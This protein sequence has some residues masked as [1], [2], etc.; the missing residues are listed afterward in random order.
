[1]EVYKGVGISVLGQHLSHSRHTLGAA[2]Y[3]AMNGLY[4][5]VLLAL[6]ASMA[7]ASPVERREDL[8]A[9]KCYYY[10]LC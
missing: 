10:Y 1:V 2:E 5:L 9:G 7:A 6:S 4:A 8:A 3:L